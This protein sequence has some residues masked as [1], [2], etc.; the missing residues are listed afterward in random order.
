MKE[1][2]AERRKCKLTEIMLYDNKE[3]E[4]YVKKAVDA[5]I[6]DGIYT[7]DMGEDVHSKNYYYVS[8]FLT[9]ALEGKDVIAK[10]YLIWLALYLSP[11]FISVFCPPPDLTNAPKAFLVDPDKMIQMVATE[12]CPFFYLVG[13]MISGTIDVRTFV[14]C[15]TVEWNSMDP[16]ENMDEYKAI[17]NNEK[18]TEHLILEGKKLQVKKDLLSQ[19]YYL[20]KNLPYERVLEPA[21]RQPIALA[22]PET[23]K[24]IKNN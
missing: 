9:I 13:E 2:I 17:S 21:K 6:C 22:Q 1:L 3:L 14:T 5:L 23:I 11:T 10:K 16:W 4:F 19:K 20:Q 7:S 24:K 18:S 12:N 8:K 15:C